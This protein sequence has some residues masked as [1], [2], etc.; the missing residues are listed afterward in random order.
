[1]GSTGYAI[2]MEALRPLGSCSTAVVVFLSGEG[3]GLIVAVARIP[4][5]LHY[6]ISGRSPFDSLCSPSLAVT[7][8]LSPWI[9]WVVEIEIGLQILSRD[10]SDVSNIKIAIS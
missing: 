3:E 6:A 2:S 9:S 8:L 5:S 1:M 7:P 4:G 10:F